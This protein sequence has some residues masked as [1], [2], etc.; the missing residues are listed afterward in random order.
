MT[1]LIPLSHGLDQQPNDVIAVKSGESITRQELQLRVQGWIDALSAQKGNRWAVYHSD[2]FEF[3]CILFALWQLER[4]ACI[5][6]DNRAGTVKRLSGNAD[7]LVGEFHSTQT[8]ISEP[9]DVASVDT[10]WIALKPDFIA[11]EIFTSGSTGDPKSI[12]KTIA[13]LDREI[14]VLESLWPGEAGS[15]VLATV[16]HQHIY[17]MT[18]GLFWPF[19]SGRAF[20]TR[21]CEYPEDILYKARYYPQVSLISS[22]SHLARMSSSLDWGEIAGRCNYV[23]SSAAPLARE[24]SLNVGRLLGAPVR[25][26]YGS[27]ETGAVAWRIQQPGD[28][29]ALWN[30]L[31]ELSLEPTKEGALRIRSP[32]L[33]EIDYFELPDRVEFD[34]QG[35]FKLI[36]RVD[37]IVKVEGKRVSLALIERLLLENDWIKNVRAL[38]IECIRVETAIVM[39]LSKEGQEQLLKLGR[40]SLIGIFKNL[41]AESLE[42]VVLPRRW[43]FVEQMPFNRQG[44]L[45]LD[46]LQLLFEKEVCKWPQ[47][48]KQKITEEQVVL[49]CYIPEQLIYFDGHMAGRPILPGIVQVHWAEA[50]GRNLLAVKGRFER[51]EVIKFQQVILPEYEVTISLEYNNASNKL[52]FRFESEKGVHSSGRICFAT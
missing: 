41:L 10:Q 12:S 4:T 9:H 34:E 13:Q 7:G 40:R 39:Q 24:D 28:T 48:V 5:P 16:S 31:P 52:S 49:H 33:G 30:A 22:P 38:I 29:D 18:F 51:L 20:E 42:T 37:R 44:K 3:L 46:S 11:L 15:V 32:Y 2:T 6:G 35:G 21:L 45:P 36:G 23:V 43:R 47:I 50:Y 1:Q 14:E 27:S 17:G 19:S 26:I 8:G 25:E